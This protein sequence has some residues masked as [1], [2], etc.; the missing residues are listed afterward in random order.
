MK[1]PPNTLTQAAA[2]LGHYAEVDAQLAEVEANRKAQL[3]RIN[4]A[5]DVDAARLTGELEDLRKRLQPW[6]DANAGELA[7][8]RKSAQISGC[9]IGYRIGRPKLTHGFENDSKAV[10]A[11]RATRWS[12]QTTRVAYALD[13][14][15]T[16]KLLQL[17]GK[18]GEDLVGMGFKVDQD[19]TFYIERAEPASTLSTS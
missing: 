5:A 9:T 1:R 12:K 18:A 14:T 10:E 19:E 3:G 7:A 11:L 17:E 15:A 13:R 2:L 4:T 16:L 8:K 6:W